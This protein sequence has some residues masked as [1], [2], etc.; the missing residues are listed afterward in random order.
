MVGQHPPS[1]HRADKGNVKLCPYKRNHKGFRLV[2]I[3]FPLKKRPKNGVRKGGEKSGL[4][5]KDKFVDG[6]KV[7]SPDGK[8][9]VKKRHK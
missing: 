8:H 6:P 4:H 7:R 3:L 2:L 5:I 1:D 9:N